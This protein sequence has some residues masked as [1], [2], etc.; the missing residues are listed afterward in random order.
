MCSHLQTAM[1]GLIAVFH[2]YSGK[3]GDK[4]KLSKAELKNLLQGELTE[5]LAASKDPMVVEKI[6]HDLDEN[7][8]GEVDFQEFVVLVAALTVAC[9]E[10]FIDED[11]SMKCKKDP[12]SK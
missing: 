2:S 7:K 5:F 6:M 9:N 3:E 1:E 8:D 10:F 11:K 4:Y 12:G